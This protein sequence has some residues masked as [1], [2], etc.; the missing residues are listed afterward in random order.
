MGF[1]KRPMLFKYQV[2]FQ[3]DMITL[4]VV[5][6]YCL[7]KKLLCM[8][9][10]ILLKYAR[11]TDDELDI[12]REKFSPLKMDKNELFLDAGQICNRAGL[13]IN[14]KFILSQVSES[15]N[16]A[17]L[18][19]FITG[20][21]IS[22]YYS[23]LKNYPS[24]TYIKALKKAELLVITKK[25][26]EYLYRTIPKFQIFG[27]KLAEESFIRLAETI[28]LQSV[29]PK[30][31]YQIFMANKI[32]IIKEFPQYMIAS[33]LRISPEWLSKIRGHK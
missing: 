5:K 15:G 30:E 32:E 25:D 6:R 7:S 33:Y 8:I 3:K 11:F 2:V 4:S 23:L 9:N 20:E 22:D 21:L 14:G 18:D 10:E 1:K 24:K 12:I 28:K 27:R 17:I 19:F 26:L 29:S 31:R 16:E 13:I